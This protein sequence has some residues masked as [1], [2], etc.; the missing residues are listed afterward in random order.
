VRRRRGRTVRPRPAVA[1]T[2]LVLLALLILQTR[3]APAPAWDW[4][5]AARIA[6]PYDYPEGTFNSWEEAVDQ[7]VADG[8]NVI[9]DWHAVSDSWQALYEPLLSQDLVKMAR[10][11]D[12]VHTRHPGV[13][14]VVYVAPMEYVTPGVDEDRDGRVDPGREA[15]SL[16]LQHPDWLQVGLDGRKAVFYGSQPGMPFW[17]CPDCEDVWLTPAHPEYRELALNQARRIASTGVDGVWFDVPFLRFDF[18][19]GWQDQWPTFDPWAVAQFEAETGYSVPQPPGAHWPDWDDPA[20]RAF[21][22]WR[23]TL[24]ARFLADYE[25]ALKSVNPKIKLIVETSVGPNVTATQQGS[26]TLDLPAVSDLTAHEHGGPWRS[27]DTHYYL[28]LRFLSDLLFWRHTDGEQ[29]AWLLSYVKSGEPDTLSTARLHAATVLTAGMNY[30]T[31]GNETMAGMPDPDFRWR[32]FRWLASEERTY[33]GPWRPYANA[34]LVYSQQTL[35]FL[36]RGSWEGDFAY[37]DA[38]SGMT[39]MLLESRIPFEVVSERELDRLGDYELAIL[40][41][42]AA[43]SPQQAQTIRDYVAQGGKL[44]ATGPTSL[45]TEEGVQLSDFRLADVLGVHYPEVQPGEV[46]VNDYGSG[47]SVFFYSGE[48]GW[49]F[50]PELDY[51]W[52]A[53]PWEGGVPDPAG[54]ERARRA[55]LDDLFASTGVEPLLS[56]SAPRGVIVLPYWDATGSRLVLRAL[57][58][59]GIGLGDA[60]PTPT[61]VEVSLRLPTGTTVVSAERMEFLGGR[62]AQDFAPTEG[63]VGVSFPL[64]DHVVVEFQIGMAGTASVVWISREGEVHGAGLL[65]RSA[66]GMLP[67]W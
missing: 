16:A 44:I 38:F 46:Y 10:H 3:S 42:T 60:V 17:V 2:L 61:T 24:T 43:M 29:P 53:E 55:F 45:Y 37:H 1:G 65:L 21:V 64:E 48:P 9:L 15:R 13:R 33:Y 7:A 4:T 40:P 12:Y 18:G 54:A 62:Q 8:A 59:H 32:L 56:A 50:T 11:A 6:T 27:A 5:L 52:S 25:A 30:Y 22:R 35:D 20:W 36:D 66:L 63:A 49:A 14:Y 67:R 28:W 51:F 41:M 47:H 31:S 58:L 34:A 26:S 23:Y 19:E 57:N 39:M